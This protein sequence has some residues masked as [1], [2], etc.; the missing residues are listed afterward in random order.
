MTKQKAKRVPEEHKPAFW[1]YCEQLDTEL[2]ELGDAVNGLKDRIAALESR[3]A[4]VVYVKD[5][6]APAPPFQPRVGFDEQ[7]SCG[8]AQPKLYANGIERH[9]AERAQ[10]RYFATNSQYMEQ[11]RNAEA[12]MAEHERELI[13]AGYINIHDEWYHPDA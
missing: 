10:P 5:V 9:F 3:Q 2:A 7:G 12:Q 11:L 8:K 4:I 13:A 1:A 6:P